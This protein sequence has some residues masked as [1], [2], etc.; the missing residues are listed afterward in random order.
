M[1]YFISTNFPLFDAHFHIIDPQ[2]PLI[3]NQGYI[4]D[5]F[6]VQDYL[7][8]CPKNVLGGAVVSGSFQAFDQMY[9]INALNQLGPNYVGVTQL[10]ASVSDEEIIDLHQQGVRAIRFN[11]NRG[12]SEGID[13]LESM[14]HRVHHLVGWHVEL[15][16]DAQTLTNLL[17]LLE[18]LPQIVIDH[19][20]LSQ[21]GLPTL[22]KLVKAGAYVKATGF[23][24]VSLNIP[25]TLRII[26]ELNPHAI[27]FGTDLPS[28]RAPRPF[29]TSDLD[30]IIDAL[31]E[32][33]AH[34]AFYENAINLYKPINAQMLQTKPS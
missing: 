19:L 33:F 6:T 25:K 17:P 22:L 21:E 31:E 7:Q 16:V 28:T 34:F 4:P 20:G 26:A 29:L 2:F 27:L 13:L 23:G 30:V 10:P 14:A 11:L 9:L 8:A 32:Q 12:G 24:R 1:T 18:S 5:A 3:A 15:Y